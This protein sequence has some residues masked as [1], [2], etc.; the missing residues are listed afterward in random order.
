MEI[1][2][3][4]IDEGASASPEDELSVLTEEFSAGSKRKAE[5]TAAEEESE[6]ALPAIGAEPEES[7][8][9]DE[10]MIICLVGKERYA[11]PIMDVSM[12]IDYKPPTR[13]PR[14]PDFLVGI[15][16]LRGRIVTVLDARSRLGISGTPVLD[17]A[18]IIVI[19]KGNDCFGI[20]VEGIDHVVEVNRNSFEEPPEG[21]NRFA[22]DFVDGVF[23]YRKRAVAS[24]NLDLFLIFE[25]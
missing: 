3:D 16:S 11:I 15:I 24:L 9:E 25:V 5:E 6:E 2:D 14:V 4:P 17:E 19:E 10:K 23:Y 12:I 13:I 18:K 22:Q 21:I 8:G 1:E 7:D 20:R